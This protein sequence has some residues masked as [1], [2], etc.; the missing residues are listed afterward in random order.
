M[1]EFPALPL[2]T[3]AYLGDTTHLTTIEHGAYM[4]LLITAWRS[5]D[6]RLPDDDAKLARYARLTKGQW[7]RIKPT[8]AE[9]FDISS[10]GWTQGRLT[11]EWV[12]VRSVRESQIANGQA[13]ALKRKG[14]HSTKRTRPVEPIDEPKVSEASTPTPTPIYDDVDSARTPARE[15]DIPIPT[16]VHG[17]T[18]ELCRMAGVRHIDP[19]TIVKHEEIVRGWKREGFDPDTEIVPAIRQAVTEATRPIHSLQYFDPIIRQSVARKEAQQHG[20]SPGS[21]DIRN[22]VLA[23]IARRSGLR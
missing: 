1:A 8:I 17:L 19:G 11:D 23:D 9:F 5:R 15:D 4:L 20:H 10:D 2:F 18:N 12:H 7:L 21:D 16:D 3:D 22:P 14:R 13:S 6:C